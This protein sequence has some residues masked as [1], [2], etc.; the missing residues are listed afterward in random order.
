MPV[1]VCRGYENIIT[2]YSDDGFSA[3]EQGKG[4]V[5][6]ERRETVAETTEGKGLRH[7]SVRGR[8]EVNARCP[9]LAV[10]LCGV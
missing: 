9:G 4:R 8:D 10:T 7:P 5:D 3:N 1:T 6:V 2:R